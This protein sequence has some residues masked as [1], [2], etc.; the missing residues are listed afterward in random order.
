[1]GEPAQGGGIVEETVLWL[2]EQ[3]FPDKAQDFQGIFSTKERAIAA[4]K[5]DTFAVTRV[6]LDRELPIETVDREKC[7]YPLREPE[8]ED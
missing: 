8:P 6:I 1:M 4:C 7:W 2:V 5:L 3:W